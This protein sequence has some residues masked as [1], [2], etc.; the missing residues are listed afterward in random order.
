MIK[1]MLF[2]EYTE[3][4]SHLENI[5]QV[6]RQHE[7]IIDSQINKFKSNE[8]LY[9]LRAELLQVNML[10]EMGKSNKDKI[11]VPISLGINYVGK[12][13]YF[14]PDALSKDG[15]ILLEVEAGQAVDNNKFL[16]DIF[17]ASLMD[18]VEYLVIGVRNGYRGKNDFNTICNYLRMLYASTR[19]VLPLKGI[20][21]I[22]Y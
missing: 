21:I 10:V 6:F 19:I 13:R 18:Q 17:K 3:L 22:G 1:H 12:K 20:L 2:P 16:K 11:I 5:I 8:I 9:L 7:G 15:K 14:Q 4:N